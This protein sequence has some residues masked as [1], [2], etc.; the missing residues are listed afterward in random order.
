MQNYTL[1]EIRMKCLPNTALSNYKTYISVYENLNQ[2]KLI[3]KT[4]ILGF[5]KSIYEV[6]ECYTKP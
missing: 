2:K 4:G 3:E 6:Y 5:R 1:Y